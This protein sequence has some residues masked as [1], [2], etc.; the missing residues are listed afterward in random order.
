MSKDEALDKALSEM[1]NFFLV[2]PSPNDAF[3]KLDEL[4]EK[5]DVKYQPIA[6][7]FRHNLASALSAV[8]TPFRLASGSVHGS[9]FQRLH[10]AERIRARSISAEESTLAR[11][12]KKFA[13]A[14]RTKRRTRACRTFLRR[15]MDNVPLFLIFADF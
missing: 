1:R 12:S 3:A 6:L 9:H 15:R 13:N 11:N 7:A 2:P 4:I 5:R 8:A 14:R 10:T